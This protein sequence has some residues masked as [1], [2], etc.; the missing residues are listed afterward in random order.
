MVVVGLDEAGCGPALGSLWAGA[1]YLPVSIEGL[2]DS[3]KLSE[4][5]RTLLRGRIVEHA[6]YGVGEV[7]CTEIDAMGMAEARRLVFERALDDYMARG[8]PTPTDLQVD[9]TIFRPWSHNGVRIP[10]TCTPGADATIPCVSAASIM[11]KTTRD[12]QILDW[13]DRDPTLQERYDLRANKGYLSARHMDG[14][15]AH[16]QCEW[17]RTSF[18]IRALHPPPST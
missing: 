6:V 18:H 15:R 14:L 5:K 13:C 9:G 8:G 11:A 7:T 1:V 2:G 17:H 10:H 4:K 3:K 16:G 12:M